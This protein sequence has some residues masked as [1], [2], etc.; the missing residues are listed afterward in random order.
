MACGCWR[1]EA[2]WSQC[3]AWGADVD[4]GLRF[5]HHLLLSG[6]GTALH[7]PGCERSDK[8]HCKS[9]NPR[10]VAAASR[11][12]DLTRYACGPAVMEWHCISVDAMRLVKYAGAGVWFGESGAS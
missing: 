8:L 5:K 12:G 10:L 2:R 4:F 9:P 3:P 11:H 7:W 1:N 6:N